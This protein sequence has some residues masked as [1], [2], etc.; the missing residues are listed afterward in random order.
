METRTLIVVLLLAALAAASFFAT[1]HN[2]AG[3][4]ET[5]TGVIG[6]ADY[7]MSGFTLTT[8]D[9]K[10]LKLSDLKGKTILLNFW[11]TWC[12][13]CVEEMTYYIKIHEKFGSRAAGPFDHGSPWHIDYPQF[14]HG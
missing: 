6:N 4:E 9:G 11:A 10:T 2:G 13:P 5:G 1:Q 12:P 3:E 7:T 14:L 8:M